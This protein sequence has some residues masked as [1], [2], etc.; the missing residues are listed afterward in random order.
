MS[1]NLLFEFLLLFI[2]SNCYKNLY[3]F[4][5]YFKTLLNTAIYFILKQI[6]SI[7]DTQIICT[8]STG[9]AGV[10]PVIVNSPILGS[11]NFN[12]QYTY[13]LNVTSLSHTSGSLGGLLPLTIIGNGF[14]NATQVTICGQICP[15]ILPAR[16]L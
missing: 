7:T 5:I 12:I 8:L 15:V 3:R 6:T 10:W 14:S 13:L 2:H 9:S 4:V 16:Y 1:G 11:S